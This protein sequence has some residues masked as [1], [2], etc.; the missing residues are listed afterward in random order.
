[1]DELLQYAGTW[2]QGFS[3]VEL[4]LMAA[5]VVLLLFSRPLLQ[6]LSS[7]SDSSDAFRGKL[8]IFRAANL[9]VLSLVVFNSLIL[10]I[11]SHSWMTRLLAALLVAFLA[12]LSAHVANYLIKRRFGRQREI[13]GE[14]IWSETYNVRV[15][16]LLSAILLFVVALIAVVRI[17]GLDSLLEAGGVIGFVGVLLALT[18]SSWAPDIISGLVILNSR[19]IEEGDVIEVGDGESV[20]GVVYKTKIFH[21]EVLN[22]VNNHRIMFS[23]AG[24]R[25]MVIH[26]LS[27]FAS[28]KGLREALVFKIGYEVSEARVHEMFDKAFERATQKVGVCVEFK[29]EPEVRV[30]DAGDYAVEW[31]VYYYTKDVRYLLRTRQ[32]LRALIIKTA[33]EEGISLATP[34]LHDVASG[35][36]AK[37]N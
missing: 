36:V 35:E 33:A 37:T 11:A 32:L 14:K 34:L 21:T 15:L 19:L 29:Y 22:L 12:Y 8:H 16:S 9:L 30:T 10:P 5:N 25:G 18:Q 17:L 3:N 2:L 27:K 31:T 20:L 23:N 6:Y 13:N 7:K 28:A 4:T 1:M 24:L 26:N